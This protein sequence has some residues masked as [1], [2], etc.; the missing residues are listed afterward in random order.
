VHGDIIDSYAL[1]GIKKI[2]DEM[3][4]IPVNAEVHCSDGHAGRC[5]HVIVNPITK[6]I[7]HLVV[8][9]N[10]ESNHEYMVP[11]DQVKATTPDLIL[12]KCSRD[13]LKSMEPFEIEEYIHT[14]VPDYESWQ[15][16]YLAWPLVLPAEEYAL[17]E[18]DTYIPMKYENIPQGEVAVRRGAQVK[19][20]DGYVGK[21]DELLINSKNMQV[22]F[23]VLRERNIWS[24]REVT[25]P[26]S[27]IDHVDDGGIT[28]KLDKKSIE[29]LPT[30]PVQRWMLQD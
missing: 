27:Q 11:V 21:V 2:G 7:T 17:E 4:D 28:L 20:T 13:D 24:Q 10:W 9:S 25:I 15:D 26:V 12:L 19:A 3:I 23:L 29:E 5:T 30:V 16:G 22:M 8:K 14:K 6:R 1:T 18:V